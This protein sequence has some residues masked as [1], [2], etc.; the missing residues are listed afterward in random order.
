MLTVEISDMYGRVISTTYLAEDDKF[1][2]KELIE[3]SGI[4]VIKFSTRS[5]SR[6]VKVIIS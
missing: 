3:N 6:T 4:Y 1:S 2:F 5:Q